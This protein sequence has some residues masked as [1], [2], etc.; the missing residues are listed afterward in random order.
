MEER[1]RASLPASSASVSRGVS[2]STYLS[3]AGLSLS[4][5]VAEGWKAKVSTVCSACKPE[6]DF[7]SDPLSTVN[8]ALR[9]CNK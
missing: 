6:L 4:V 1:K 9:A 5:P 2:R 7:A 3:S 8:E